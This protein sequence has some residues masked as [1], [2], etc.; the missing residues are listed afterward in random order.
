EAAADADETGVM[1]GHDGN[2]RLA[3]AGLT[4]KSSEFPGHFRRPVGD[5]GA[6]RRH[7]MLQLL[8]EILAVH[9]N[10]CID[11]CVQLVNG[12]VR[13]GF[14]RRLDRSGTTQGIF[15]YVGPGYQR[16]MPLVGMRQMPRLG[17]AYDEKPAACRANAD[18]A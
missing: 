9:V 7:R 12:G 5:L 14:R 16:V 1:A 13:K 3:E 18:I 17:S 6:G 4:V 11:G 2:A 15:R 8:P 10:D